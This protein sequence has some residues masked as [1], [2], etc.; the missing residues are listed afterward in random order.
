MAII[1]GSATNGNDDI[2]LDGADDILEALAGDDTVDAGAGNDFIL[3]Q[4]NNDFIRGEQGNDFVDGGSG[5]DEVRGNSDNDTVEG[6]AGNDTLRGNSGNDDLIAATGN[7][8]LF[9]GSGNDTLDGFGFSQPQQQNQ[10]DI[11]T[12][13]TGADEFIL[14]DNFSSFYLREGNSFATITDFNSSQGDKIRINGNLTNYSLEKGINVSGASAL[15]TQI[16]RN[17]DVIGIVQ[18]NTDVFLV[19]D[20]LSA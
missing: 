15:D 2:D 10:Q 4:Q 3:G 11:L 1:S 9:G 14:G 17:G 20:F 12:G 8:N 13:G 5:D 7:D 6:D 19:G 16:F 18:D